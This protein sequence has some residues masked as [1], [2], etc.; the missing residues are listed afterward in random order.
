MQSSPCDHF[1]LSVE[2]TEA[3]KHLHANVDSSSHA[4]PRQYANPH[5]G[6]FGAYHQA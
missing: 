3:N 2:Y 6:I 1:V 4:V 5:L